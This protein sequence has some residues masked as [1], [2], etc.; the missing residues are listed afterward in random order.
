MRDAKRSIQYR[1]TNK[2][3]PRRTT[4]FEVKFKRCQKCGSD[5]EPIDPEKPPSGSSGSSGTVSA[6]AGGY[7]G[8]FVAGGP[9]TPSYGNPATAVPTDWATGASDPDWASHPCE[10]VSLDVSDLAPNE[11]R[12]LLDVLAKNLAAM[13]ARNPLRERMPSICVLH[14]VAECSCVQRKRLGYDLVWLD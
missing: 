10:V 12:A 8:P 13:Q 7:M 9:S 2:D 14:G 6:A 1:C 11:A 4:P 5:L 3:C